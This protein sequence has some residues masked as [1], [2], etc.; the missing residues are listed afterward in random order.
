MREQLSA[1][2]PRSSRTYSLGMALHLL[3]L[4]GVAV[5]AIS[6][7]HTVGRKI[8]DLFSVVVETVL[9]A[10]GGGTVRDVLLDDRPVFADEEPPG[11]HALVR[12]RMKPLVRA[13]LRCVAGIFRYRLLKGA[14][15]PGRQITRESGRPTLW[16]NLW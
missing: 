9:T 7:A 6:G 11:P 3:D 5:F 14:G 16:P 12:P 4:F 1:S 8:M 10:I 13:R 15:S 2:P